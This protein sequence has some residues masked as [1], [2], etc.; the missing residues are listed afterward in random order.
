[1]KEDQNSKEPLNVKEDK[2]EK[3]L[4]TPPVKP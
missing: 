1:V 3:P 4:V 2:A